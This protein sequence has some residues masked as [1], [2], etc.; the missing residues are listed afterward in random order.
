VRGLAE[1]FGTVVCGLHAYTD[2]CGR[3]WLLVASD[4][5]IAIRQPFVIPVFTADDGYPSDSFDSTE[6]ISTLNW[7]NTLIYEAI[8]GSLLRASGTDTAPFNSANYLR[9]FKDAPSASY[10]VQIEYSFAAAVTTK[11]IVSIAI[12]GSGDL[13]T[14]AYLQADLEFTAGGAYLVKLY[15]VSAARSRSLL[16]Q[17]DVSGSLTTPTG[18]LTLSYTRTLIG[19]NPVFIPKAS[20]VPTGGALQEVSGA[21]LTQL[22]D[23][24]LGQVSAIG[25]GQ[26]AAILIVSGGAV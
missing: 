13:S 11:Q 9:W 26:N 14:G 12:K 15:K 1:R 18:F 24:D 23:T 3:E 10:E 19:S 6:G 22:E 7:R 4:S 16:G 5:A 8:G 2:N 20:V 21:T 17:I 25:C